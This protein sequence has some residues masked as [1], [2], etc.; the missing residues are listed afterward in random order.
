ML[1]SGRA[2]LQSQSLTKKNFRRFPG[3]SFS[4]AH[5]NA[6]PQCLKTIDATIEKFITYTGVSH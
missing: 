6:V 5:D 1:I 2:P 4:K 3:L